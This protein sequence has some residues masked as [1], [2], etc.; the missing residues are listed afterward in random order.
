MRRSWEAVQQANE[1]V[2]KNIRR[3]ATATSVVILDQLAYITHVGDGQAYLITEGMNRSRAI[4][5]WCSG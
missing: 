2:G 3:A 1:A 4:T 5:P